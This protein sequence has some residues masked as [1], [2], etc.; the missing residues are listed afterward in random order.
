MDLNQHTAK[1]SEI[2]ISYQGEGP[3][4]GMKQ[5]F[6]RFYGCSLGCAYCDTKPV[7]FDTFTKRELLTKV[8]DFKDT[9]DAVAI[10]GGEPLEQV[11]FLKEFLPAYRKAA[12]K[13]IYLETNGLL[14]ENLM[15]LIDVIDTIA[16]DIKLP[17]STR[18]KE[19][20]H[21][22]KKFL[23]IA[24]TKDVFVKAIITGETA[25][26]DLKRACGI[27]KGIDKKIPFILQPVDPKYDAE[28]SSPEILTKFK[29]K[30]KRDLKD[31]RIIPQQHK[32]AGVK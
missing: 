9:F 8:L 16:M 11:E 10:T 27:V 6:I 12:G 17:S 1:I 25:W 29:M 19:F 7:L 32:E 31:V 21:E 4:L 14:Y 15:E 13:S 22:H 20:W 24:K 23:E 3:Y 2:F 30:L 28:E 18:R 26:E 5:L